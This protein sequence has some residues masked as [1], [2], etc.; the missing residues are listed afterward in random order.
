VTRQQAVDFLELAGEAALSQLD[1]RA[2]DESIPSE[3]QE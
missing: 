2:A 1:A 3:S